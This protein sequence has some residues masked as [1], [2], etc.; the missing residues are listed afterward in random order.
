MNY[1]MAFIV[2]GII[3]VLG[4]LLLDLTAI[5]PARILVIG[6]VSGVFFGAIGIWDKLIEIAGAGATVPIIGFGNAL[7]NGVKSAIVAEGFIG[8]FTGG[9][10]ACAAGLSA[11]LVFGFIVSLIK[12][13]NSQE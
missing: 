9:F 12:K 5:T 1:V 11:S 8:I 2:G 4:Q 7:A 3:C 6:V 13:P 10:A